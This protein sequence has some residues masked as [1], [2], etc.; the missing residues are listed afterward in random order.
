MEIEDVTDFEAGME[1]DGDDD[2][3]PTPLAIWSELTEQANS[4]EIDADFMARV[5]ACE[6]PGD[7]GDTSRRSPS[8]PHPLLWFF[9]VD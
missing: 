4:T 7:E 8:K 6:T 5:G 9:L 3:H 2:S 1:I